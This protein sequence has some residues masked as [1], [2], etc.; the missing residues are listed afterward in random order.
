[1]KFLLVDNYDNIVTTVDLGDVGINGAKTYFKGKI[2]PN[3][4]DFDKLWRVMTKQQY[5]RQF[6]ATLQNRQMDKMKYEWWKEE[7]T[8]LDIEAPITQSEDEMAKQKGRR[9]VLSVD[10]EKELEKLALEIEAEAI[11]MKLDYE[12]NPSEE[13]G[14]VVVIHQESEFLDEE[15]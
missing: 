6:K 15:E 4:S 13:S 10:A 2:L 14:S 12:Q 1:M 9:R 5:D 8:Y 11:Q 7:E 3:D